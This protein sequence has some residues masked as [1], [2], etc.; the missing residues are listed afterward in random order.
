MTNETLEQKINKV[1]ITTPDVAIQYGLGL[2]SDGHKLTNLWIE[3]TNPG[4][5]NLACSYCYASG[6]EGVK[7]SLSQNEWYQVLERARDVGI[8]SIGIPGAGEPFHAAAKDKTM[9]ILEKCKDLGIYVTLFTT[10]QFITPEL[11]DKL[12][13]LPVELMIKGNSL[14]PEVQD[15]FVS[16]PAAGR[17]IHGYGTSRNNALE[18]L[19]SK[20]YNDEARCQAQF[21]RKSRMAI[22]TSIMTNNIPEPQAK[23]V[24]SEEIRNFIKDIRS[25]DGPVTEAY[26]KA[27]KQVQNMNFDQTSNYREIAFLHTFARLNNIIFDV[28]TVLE[29]GRAKSCD[30]CVRDERTKAKFQELQVID[31]EVFGYEWGINTAYVGVACERPRR[32]LYIDFKGDIRPCIGATGVKLGNARTTDLM[33]AW[34]SQEMQIIRAKKYHGKCAE[35]C[36][37]YIEKDKR[38]GNPLCNSC[39]GRSTENLTNETL[40]EKGFVQTIGCWNFRERNK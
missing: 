4:H 26:L 3:T 9:A 29:R 39:L 34:N 12:Y 14:M 15:K 8:T 24:S 10:G 1:A 28:D 20:G 2:A 32:H 18:L 11:A 21:G 5:C 36:A 17:E 23:P 27:I 40:L 7:D 38:T 19:I 13:D 6:G 35:Q 33:E 30:L 16:N 31:K 37:N 25:Y 22:V